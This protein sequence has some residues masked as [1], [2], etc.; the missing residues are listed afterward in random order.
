MNSAS[1]LLLLLAW[2]LSVG[3]AAQR[4]GTL[5]GTVRDAETGEEL[6][7]AGV[8]LVGTYLNA[9]TDVNGNF[10]LAKVP[11]GEFSVKVQMMGYGT[12]QINGV[13]VTLGQT[14]T[15]NVK[16]SSDINELQTVTVVG[17]KTAVDLERA[18]S[19]RMIGTDELRQMNVRNVEDAVATQAGVTKTTDGLQIRGARV[20][21]TEYLVDGISAQDPL[22]GTG[23]GVNVQSSA[24]QSIKVTTSGASAEFGGGSSGVVS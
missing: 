15:L 19:E 14:T 6:P 23:F 11:V 7:G 21:E 2:L 4:I 13:R 18:G 17:K 8:S 9:V 12:K 16:L 22:A 1:K 24:I 20:Y 3:A 5:R 10:V